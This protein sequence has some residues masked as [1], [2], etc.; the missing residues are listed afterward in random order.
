MDHNKTKPDNDNMFFR[1]SS[2][3]RHAKSKNLNDSRLVL[4]VS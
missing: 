4:Q 2:N 3:I 1:V